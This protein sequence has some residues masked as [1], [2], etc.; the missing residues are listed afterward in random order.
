MPTVCGPDEEFFKFCVICNG[1]HDERLHRIV[2]IESDLWEEKVEPGV[3]RKDGPDICAV[4]LETDFADLPPYEGQRY[5]LADKIYWNDYEEKLEDEYFDP[6][7]LASTKQT[8]VDCPTEAVRYSLSMAKVLDDCPFEHVYMGFD[9]EKEG[10][11]FQT[12][13]YLNGFPSEGKDY[14]RHILWQMR[15]YEN[16]RPNILKKG[17]PPA[18]VKFFCH[19]RL[20][21]VGKLIRDDMHHLVSYL[22]INDET[23]RKFKTVELDQLYGFFFTL[24]YSPNYA[25]RYLTATQS[26]TKVMKQFWSVI[27]PAGLKSICRLAWPKSTLKKPLR[28]RLKF[29]NFDQHNGPLTAGEIDY[30]IKDAFFSR[31]AGLVIA[32]ILGIHLWHLIRLYTPKAEAIPDLLSDALLRILDALEGDDSSSLGAEEKEVFEEIKK[33][34]DKIGKYYVEVQHW[35]RRSRKK[36]ELALARLEEFR[37]GKTFSQEVVGLSKRTYQSLPLPHLLAAQR[38]LRDP[39]KDEADFEEAERDDDATDLKTVVESGK[40]ESDGKSDDKSDGKPDDKSDGKS[41]D[42][43]D[44]KGDDTSRLGVI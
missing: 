2:T 17:V 43:S 33:N 15:T 5:E 6:L 16:R 24:C 18:V 22:K 32:S 37:G 23:A 26:C 41:G 30:A 10:A 12:S 7:T 40:T 39:V 35:I 4:P 1:N 38:E 3:T 21:F 25:M 34:L 14:E 42:K 31:G 28:Y 27:C 36:K 20:V 44:G 9:S 8:V 11:T 29:N 19:P 13:I